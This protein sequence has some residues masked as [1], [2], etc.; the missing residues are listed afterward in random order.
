M[1]QSLISQP[2]GV[3][4][5]S[6]L[7][8]APRLTPI[9]V[10]KWTDPEGPF[11]IYV[12]L[13]SR[14]DYKI[15]VYI[16][17]K[18][19]LTAAEAEKLPVIIDFHGGGFVLGSCLEQAP[20]CSRLARELGAVV[21]TVDYRMGPI[22]KFPA[23]IEDAEDV[24]RAVLEPSHP[25]GVA[26]RE[27]IRKKIVENAHLDTS[28]VSVS[29]F[30][31]GGNLALNLA[32]SLTEETERTWPSIFGATY[33]HPVPFLLY[34]PSFDSRQLPSERPKKSLIAESE[35]TPGT[36]KRSFWAAT[37]D[38]LAPTYLPRDM[39]GHPRASPGLAAVAAVHSAARMLLVLPENDS[40]AD[41]SEAWVKKVQED[42]TRT[43]HLRVER[44]PAMKHGWTQF[45]DSFLK[46]EEKQAKIEVFGKTIE[47]VRGIWAGDES[48]L[49]TD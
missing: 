21:I 39:A 42:G 34:Y 47:F 28:R 12:E 41:Q 44:Y 26:L 24:L 22:Y 49:K 37:D 5:R 23:A 8:K 30:S 29:G 33:Q 9:Q 2:F 17:I 7:V 36:S 14:G 19:N 6:A 25:S 1:F 27:S 35:G 32:L 20:F 43:K 3:L 48:V 31:S 13:P 40:L 16:F 38:L 4:W 11:P 45:P 46:D 18:K 10:L 15:P